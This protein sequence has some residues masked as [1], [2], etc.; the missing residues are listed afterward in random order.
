MRAAKSFSDMQA[1][2]SK[3]LQG[4]RAEIEKMV[5]PMPRQ[6]GLGESVSMPAQKQLDPFGDFKTGSRAAARQFGC[7]GER[8]SAVLSNNLKVSDIRASVAAK[9]K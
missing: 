8:I 7:Q 1:Q 4:A 9:K 5:G 6:D 2:M 3:D